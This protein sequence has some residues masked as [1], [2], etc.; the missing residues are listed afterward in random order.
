M[1]PGVRRM[2]GALQH[3]GKKLPCGCRKILASTMLMSRIIYLM[4]VWGG[5]TTN[6]LRKV[7]V[8]QNRV[9]RWL[10]KEDQ[11]ESPP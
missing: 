9:A 2:L 4:P 3:L 11:G 1:L 8:L 5:T 7:Q 10:G 6:H